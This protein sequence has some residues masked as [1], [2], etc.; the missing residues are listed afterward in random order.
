M[1]SLKDAYSRAEHWATKRQLLSIVAADLPTNV[2][3]TEFPD[4]TD[5]KIKA[6]RA[7]AYFWGKQKHIIFERSCQRLFRPGCSSR[8]HTCSSSALYWRANRALSCFY[9]ISTHNNRY[10]VW[11]TETEA[12]QWGEDNRSGC[13]S[14]CYTNSNCVAISCIL[15]RNNRHRWIQAACHLFFVC[16][17]SK[18]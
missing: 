14:Q 16:H 17:S 10:A 12:K 6:A 7:L 18:M 9:S 11:R 5:W 3:K 1:P 2:L 15:Q 8:D 13:D 4:L